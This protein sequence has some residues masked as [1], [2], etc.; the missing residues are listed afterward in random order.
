MIA[1]LELAHQRGG[2]RRHA[3]RGRARG[4]GA[5][6]GRHARLEHRDRGIGEARVLEARLGAVEAR[7]ALF[8]AVVD[9]ALGQEHRLAVLAELRSQDAGMD[10]PGLGAVGMRVGTR[11]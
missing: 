10:E 4:L 9:V 3:A 11:T 5:L 8:G 1:G 2:D 7:L 6:E